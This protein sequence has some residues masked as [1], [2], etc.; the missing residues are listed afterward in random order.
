MRLLFL[1]LVLQACAA[2]SL[3]LKKN[4]LLPYKESAQV[5]KVIGK[6][7]S[8]RIEAI[9]D[10]R[11][12]SIYGYAYTGVQYQKTPLYMDSDLSKLMTDYLSDSFELRNIPVLKGEG[13]VTASNIIVDIHALWVEEV[14]ED[15][16]PE[17]ARCR[18][19]MAF[20]IAT[21]SQ[22]WSGR[23]WTE[24]T[25]SGDLSDGTERLAPTMA[26]CLN[27][28]LEKLVQDKKF[29]TTISSEE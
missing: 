22:R 11:K 26:S 12:Q 29:L 17:K 28:I 13:A 5:T 21:K 9:N 18:A 3:V 25:S 10:K 20:H 8:L 4:E 1:T 6:P 2:S 24:F 23:Y 7:L 16:Q 27:E 19:D 14:I 15:Y